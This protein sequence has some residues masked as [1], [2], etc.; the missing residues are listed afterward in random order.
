[1]IFA[2]FPFSGFDVRR[3]CARGG[4]WEEDVAVQVATSPV[5]DLNIVCPNGNRLSFME[6]GYHAGW[7]DRACEKLAS[8]MRATSSRGVVFLGDASLSPGVR[9]V[10]TYAELVPKMQ[11][12]F[13]Q[14]GVALVSEAPGITLAADGVHWRIGS[15][16]AVAA[17]VDALIAAAKSTTS[18]KRGLLPNLWHWKYNSTS[19]AH[20]PTCK[21]C[22][23]RASDPHLVSG[24]HR[25]NAGGTR[26]SFDFPDRM[27]YCCDGVVFM[28]DGQ[29]LTTPCLRADHPL[30]CGTGADVCSRMITRRAQRLE[31]LET[32]GPL[33][34]LS[35]LP[36]Q[37]MCCVCWG[38]GLA[39]ETLTF[40]YFASGRERDAFV[41]V[42]Q[43]LVLK[44]HRIVD[45]K[46]N[47]NQED[48]SI[49]FQGTKSLCVNACLDGM[50]RRSVCFR[51]WCKQNIIQFK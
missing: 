25:A 45:G 8:S 21:L 33:C 38:T 6:E 40:V 15:Q 34:P 49:F 29:R 43:Q 35:G 28:Q 30:P 7:L 37:L 39:E 17:L 9:N 47:A 50:G 14:H 27:R 12:K 48:S 23:K 1:M 4:A 36:Q 24:D 46:R 22:D 13:R 18:I 11:L 10:V 51:C 16:V 32:E 5:V 2:S 19:M 31:I 42:E 3:W 41:S 26:L 44:V 20:Y